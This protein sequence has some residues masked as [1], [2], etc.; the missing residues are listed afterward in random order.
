MFFSP[1][2]TNRSRDVG[3]RLANEKAKN[4]K[5]SNVIFTLVDQEVAM[6]YMI[7]C[8][9]MLCTCYVPVGILFLSSCVR[10]RCS[11]LTVCLSLPSARALWPSRRPCSLP[12]VPV[13]PSFS[14]P[15]GP[16]PLRGRHCLRSCV[17]VRSL[18]VCPSLLSA[19]ALWPSTRPGSPSS[20][21][22]RPSF[23]P[24]CGPSPLRACHGV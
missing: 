3:I 8:A 14:P 15:C 6:P 16:S 18:L 1:L 23:G 19:R 12:F 11:S 7:S 2:L 24:P 17:T 5:N 10:A 4:P 9:A 22:V 13:S 20:V 21:P